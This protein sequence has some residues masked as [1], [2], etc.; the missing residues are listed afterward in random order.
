LWLSCTKQSPAFAYSFRQK[1]LAPVFY[2]LTDAAAT[3]KIEIKGNADA[4]LITFSTNVAAYVIAVPTI[5]E[6][7]PVNTIF[8]KGL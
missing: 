4:M 2:N 5:C 7:L 8:R 3:S 6:A 1:D